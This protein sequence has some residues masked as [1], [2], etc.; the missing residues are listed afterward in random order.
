M[1]CEARQRGAKARKGKVSSISN[2]R[3]LTSL[4]YRLPFY[5]SADLEHVHISQHRLTGRYACGATGTKL[6]SS[7]E[8]LVSCC[9]LLSNKSSTG[10]MKCQKCPPPISGTRHAVGNN[11]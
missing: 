5:R 8:T 9:E 1:R 3:A 7:Y 2:S 11:Q 10:V 6:V 4:H